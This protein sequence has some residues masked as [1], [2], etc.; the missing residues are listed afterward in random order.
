MQVIDT[1]TDLENALDA[2]VCAAPEFGPVREKTGM[3][4]LRRFAGGF[5]GLLRIV[6]GQ[7]VSKASAAAIWRRVEEQLS[8]LDPERFITAPEGRFRAAGLSGPKISTIN[9]LAEA[10]VAGRLD[11][12]ALGDMPDDRVVDQLT[13]VRGIGPWTAE[14]YLLSCLGRPDVW[15]AGDLALQ[16]AAADV[17]G[18][19][20]RPT[21]VEL[22]ALAA[23]WRPWRAVAARLLWVWYALPKNEGR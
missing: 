9:A 6:T 20:T 23:P 5:P 13:A 8:P 17:F 4:P 14:I 10:I 22:R 12:D 11:M 1:L 19:K 18:L 21:Q 16:V 3:P 7:Q 15:P 2:L